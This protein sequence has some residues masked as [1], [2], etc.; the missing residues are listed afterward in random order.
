M[1]LEVAQEESAITI[2]ESGKRAAFSAIDIIGIR[3]VTG[4]VDLFSLRDFRREFFYFPCFPAK[5]VLKKQGDAGIL[6]I[7]RNYVDL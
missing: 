4:T 7:Y 6:K 1:G 5:Y 3:I 2:N